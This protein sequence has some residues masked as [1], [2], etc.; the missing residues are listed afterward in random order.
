LRASTRR[1]SA[2]DDLTRRHRSDGLAAP[3]RGARAVVVLSEIA[4]PPARLLIHA[5]DARAALPNT[6]DTET[7]ANFVRFSRVVR[8]PG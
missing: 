2:A 4:V 5:S 6:P 1:S 8:N 3:R 7:A